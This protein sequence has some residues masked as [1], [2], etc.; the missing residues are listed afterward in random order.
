M[1]K[2]STKYFF[3]FKMN[4]IENKRNVRRKG[5]K[6]REMSTDLYKLNETKRVRERGIEEKNIISGSNKAAL[7]MVHC[8]C[9]EYTLYHIPSIM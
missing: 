6:Q 8:L 2:R 4:E 5:K 9:L 7:W 1:V 3:L